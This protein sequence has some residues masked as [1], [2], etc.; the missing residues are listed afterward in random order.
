M[1][2]ALR[3]KNKLG[4]VDGSLKQPTDRSSDAYLSWSFVDSAVTQWLLNSMCTELYEAYMFTSTACE[5]WKELEEKYGTISH[6]LGKA[7]ENVKSL[8][9]AVN[10][11]VSNAVNSRFVDKKKEKASRYCTHYART[12]HTAET[13]FKKHGFGSKNVEMDKK[14]MAEIIQEELKKLMKAKVTSDESPVSASYFADFTGN[15]A[16]KT[17]DYFDDNDKG[18]KWIVDFGASSHVTGNKM[19]LFNTKSLK[20]RIQCSYQMDQL[21]K[22]QLAHGRIVKNLYVLVTERKEE[23]EKSL[24]HPIPREEGAQ[25]VAIRV[26][27]YEE[28]TGFVFMNC[29]IGGNGRILLGRAWGNYSRVIF[30]FTSMSNV[31]APQG[32]N[33]FNDPSRDRTVFYGEYKCIGTGTD[34]SMRPSYVQRLSDAQVSPFL[35]ASYIDGDQCST[36]LLSFTQHRQRARK[37]RADTTRH[38]TFKPFFFFIFFYSFVPSR[39]NAQ[40]F[41]KPSCLI[42]KRFDN[43]S[44]KF[45]VP[46]R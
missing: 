31:I 44:I 30:A 45:G 41:D 33:D 11:V 22:E 26:R 3:S 19:L 7:N 13:Y 35:T 38:Q 24:G 12:G 40:R 18:V 16:L 6:G 20:G 46:M 5:I 43:H 28:N 10:V 14:V 4:F 27:S 36:C 9:E 15:L 21:T 37:G 1:I 17:C 23:A 29:S 25:A 32:W 42:A 39:T 8:A 2:I 34:M